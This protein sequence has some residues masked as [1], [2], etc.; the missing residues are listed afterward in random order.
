MTR[1]APQPYSV[2][3]Q[4]SDEDNAFVVTVPDLPGCMAHGDSPQEAAAEAQVAVGLWLQVARE[5]GQR[6]PPPR[7]HLV[8]V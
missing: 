7:R 6:I 2:I 8:A 5:R 3:I 4:W 1:S